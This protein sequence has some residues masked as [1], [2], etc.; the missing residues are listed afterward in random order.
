[1]DEDRQEEIKRLLEEAVKLDQMQTQAQF[2]GKIEEIEATIDSIVNAGYGNLP[3]NWTI[4][5]YLSRN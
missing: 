4:P 1:M 5:L 2:V 3:G